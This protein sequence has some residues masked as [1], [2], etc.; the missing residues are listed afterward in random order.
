ME[1]TFVLLM[2]LAIVLAVVI[3]AVFIYNGIVRAKNEYHNAFSQID[4]QLTRRHDLIPNLVNTTKKY[5]EHE[6]ETLT[7][8]IS[9]RNAAA[10][11]LEQVKSNPNNDTLLSLSAAEG[12][13]SQKMGGLLAVMEAYPELKANESIAQLNEEI[14]STENRIAFARQHYNDMVT[15]FNNQIAL[16]PNNLI[17]KQFSYREAALLEIDNIADKRQAIKVDL[18]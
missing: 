18:N 11:A 8:V 15:T 6:K 16:F 3:F 12:L 7:A 2:F 10:S 5:L 9:A 1:S 4:V 17:A 13:L 14:S